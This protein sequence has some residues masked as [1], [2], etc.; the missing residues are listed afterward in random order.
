MGIYLNPGNDLF[1]MSVDSEIYVDKSML[2]N[3]TNSVL[4]TDG[5]HICISRPRRFGKSMAANMLAAY[6]DRSCDS[7]ELFKD[8]AISQTPNFEKHLN[9][10]NVFQ[11]D[12]REFASGSSG[13]KEMTDKLVKAMRRD[14]LKAY[15]NIEFDEEY[16]LPEML[17]EIYSEERIAFV[18]IF[19]EWD[20]VFRVFKNDTEGQKYYLD[21]LRDLLKEK[22][23]VALDYATGIF[24]VKKYGENSALNMYREFSI[25]DAEPYSEYMGFTE[26][27]TEEL[28]EKYDLSFEKMR[29]WYNGYQVDGISIYNPQSVVLAC[30]RKV[31]SN[32]WTKTETF[33]ALKVFIQLD[34]DGLRQSVIKMIAGERVKVNTEKF[35]NDMTS[36][37]SAD[38]VI[39]LLIHLGY[40]TYSNKSG[41]AWIPN[42]EV[43][44]EF[45]NCI[46]DGG[47]E[48]VMNSIRKS[49]ELLDATLSCD[50]KKVAAVI[51]ETHRM[52][53]SIIA[54][55]NELSLSVTLALA[56]YSARKQYKII[57][58]FPSGNGFADLAFIPRK[59]VDAPAI[60]AELKYNK[61][62]G[63]AISQIKDKHY[64]ENL[65]AFN[66]EILLVGISYDEKS[67]MHSCQI[68]KVVK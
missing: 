46:E 66:G 44:Q 43:G 55:N 45:I 13:G 19:D 4:R 68:E 40:L 23:Y 56:Y 28:C 53:T 37:K 16:T 50:E 60:V 47:W 24:P 67:K 6:Y 39:T 41:E 61:E 30:T 25:N 27:E 22:N 8:L 54:Y 52:N 64:T 49:D 35:E 38:D 18:F 21:F 58:E 59:G 65:E 17:K 12:V 3:L 63:G 32:Y 5:R 51:E 29:E 57:R 15:K 14:L 42:K 20:C 26:A 34:M 10:Y 33:E 7:R 9:K 31:F 11:I 1:K 36:F 2:I 48:E 62:A